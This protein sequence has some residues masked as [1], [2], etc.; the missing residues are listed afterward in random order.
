MPPFLARSH[1]SFF[2]DADP[3]TIRTTLLRV[4]AIVWLV[5]ALLAL[6]ARDPCKTSTCLGLRWVEGDANTDAIRATVSW[7]ARAVEQKKKV[8]SIS[9]LKGEKQVYGMCLQG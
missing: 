3:N 6:G 5:H 9:L 8:F 4:T 2:S 7:V 1:R